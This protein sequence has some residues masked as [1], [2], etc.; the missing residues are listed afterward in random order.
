[1]ADEHDL[2]PGDRQCTEELR[3]GPKIQQM[4]PKIQRLLNLRDLVT[5]DTVSWVQSVTEDTYLGCNVT[6]D[7]NPI[8]RSEILL[9]RCDLLW[10]NQGLP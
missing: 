3:R 1:M 7:T 8:L 5:E 9:G 6:E 2:A 4:R 10:P